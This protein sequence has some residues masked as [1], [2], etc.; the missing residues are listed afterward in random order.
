VEHVPQLPENAHEAL[1]E[2]WG[3]YDRQQLEFLVRVFQQFITMQVCFAP[4][5]VI[6]PTEFHISRGGAGVAMSEGA[7]LGSIM[8]S[9]WPPLFDTG[10]DCTNPLFAPQLIQGIAVD[11]EY[12]PN[13][14]DALCC[15]VTCLGIVCMCTAC[16]PA[17][18]CGAFSLGSVTPLLSSQAL[19]ASE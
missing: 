17:D 13:D 3:R 6:R 16:G 19:V 8:R 12:C 4:S 10:G 14:D 1:V 5:V 7:V 9:L 18:A 11:E 2:Y 15:S